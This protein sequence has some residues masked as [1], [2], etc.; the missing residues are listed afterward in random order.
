MRPVNDEEVLRALDAQTARRGG[1]ARFASEIGM[2]PSHLREIKSGRRAVN[3]R[4]A[5]ALGYEL[6]W[7]SL[8]TETEE[9]MKK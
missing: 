2:E 4:V 9:R 3:R 5:A 8:K 1:Q 7:V 6:R